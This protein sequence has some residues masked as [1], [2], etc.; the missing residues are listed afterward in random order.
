[1][2]NIIFRSILL[3]FIG[4]LAKWLFYAILCKIRGREIKSFVEIWNGRNNSSDAEYMM[5]GMSNILVGY[6]VLVLF[7][8]IGFAI[9]AIWY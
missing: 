7:I 9:D 2:L 6:L 4:A 5:H 1:M 3:E 8:V